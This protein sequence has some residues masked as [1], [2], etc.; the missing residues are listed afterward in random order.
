M[1]S[2]DPGASTLTSAGWAFLDQA[3]QV[4]FKLK[5]LVRNTEN[6]ILDLSKFK[7]KKKNEKK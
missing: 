1:S 3:L 4:Y 2:L 7:Q 5:Y 6:N